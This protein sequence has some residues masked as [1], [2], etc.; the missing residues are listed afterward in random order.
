MESEMK[1]IEYRVRPVTRYIVTRFEAHG[2]S[3]GASSY[4]G[5]LDSEHLAQRVA[6]ALVA[7]EPGSKLVP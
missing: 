4:M 5:E 1:T 3:E 7:S 6:A 2:S